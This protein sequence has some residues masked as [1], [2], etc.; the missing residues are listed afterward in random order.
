MN[1]YLQLLTDCGIQLPDGFEQ[2][3]SALYD[4]APPPPPPPS[5]TPLTIQNGVATFTRDQYDQIRPEVLGYTQYRVITTPESE[6]P[7]ALN[8]PSLWQHTSRTRIHTYDRCYHFKWVLSHTIGLTGSNVSTAFLDQLRHDLNGQI[9]DPFIYHRI[10]AILKRNKQQ[11]LYLSIPSLIQKLGGPVWTLPPPSRFDALLADFKAL[12]N[13]FNR[14][15]HQLTRHRFPKMVF[16]VMALLDVYYVSPPY[17]L[18]WTK[19][20][21]YMV[22]L[23]KLCNQLIRLSEEDKNPSTSSSSLPV[24][25]DLSLHTNLSYFISQ[26]TQHVSSRSTISSPLPC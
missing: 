5:H 26:P 25:S 24:S 4:I 11:H 3:F 12:H 13:T 22:R 20:E 19:T 10:R 6:H 8:D 17:D 23:S 15:Q 16:V 14:H 21:V 9:M 7:F 18:P 1:P 2:Q